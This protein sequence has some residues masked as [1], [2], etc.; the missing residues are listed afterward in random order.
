MIF[1]NVLLRE[2]TKLAVNNQSSRREVYQRCRD[3]LAAGAKNLDNDDPVEYTYREQLL[4]WTIRCLE[5]D[6]RNGIDVYSDDYFPNELADVDRK[7]KQRVR[8]TR[9]RARATARDNPVVDEADGEVVA[10]FRHLLQSID[11]PHGADIAPSRLNVLKALV[12]RST[13]LA[14]SDS[15][16]AMVWIILEPAFLISAVIITYWLFGVKQIFNMDVAPFAVIGSV[17]WYLLR[18]ASI[19]V[20]SA[21]GRARA[22]LTLPPVTPFDMA[23]CEGLMSLLICS[24]VLIIDLFLAYILGIGAIPSD[25]LTF[26]VYWLGMWMMATGIGLCMGYIFLLWPYAKRV[27]PVVWRALSVFSG[28][29]FVAEQLPT[30][31]QQILLLNPLMHGLQLLRSSYFAGY[32]TE[33]SSPSYFFLFVVLFFVLGLMCERRSRPRLLPA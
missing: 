23:L 24:G 30:A 1:L 8:E 25:P 33:I 14:A 31:Y 18:S 7:L 10:A 13:H 4:E 22:M 16:I 15:K 32:R 27:T 9:E 11:S 19:K 12:I 3:A 29:L 6:I 5:K 28:V 2:I 20:A 21:V 26:L 17:T